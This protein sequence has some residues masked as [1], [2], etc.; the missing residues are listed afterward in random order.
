GGGRCVHKVDE[1]RPVRT[2]ALGRTARRQCAC[3]DPYVAVPWRSFAQPV[4]CTSPLAVGKLKLVDPSH[5][6]GDG[7]SGVNSRNGQTGKG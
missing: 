3:A 7:Q 5:M 1:V 4:D 6:D 2:R